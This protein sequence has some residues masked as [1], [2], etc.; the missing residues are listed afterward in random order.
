MVQKAL[1]DRPSLPQ[2]PHHAALTSAALPP[3]PSPALRPTA[4]A[5][6]PTTAALLPA[7]PVAALASIPQG[8]R[9]VMAVEHPNGATSCVLELDDA[10]HVA[11]AGMLRTARKLLDGSIF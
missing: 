3:L 9:T 2:T 1:S 5:P 6:T 8:T 11:R 7:S 4:S 10:G